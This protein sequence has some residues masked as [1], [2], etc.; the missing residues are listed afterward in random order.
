MGG[1]W[2][3]DRRRRRVAMALGAAAA[4]IFGPGLWHLAAMSAMQWRLDRQLAALTT[5]Q[6]QLAQEQQRLTSDPTYVE[7]LIRSTFKWA[8]KGE[9]VIPLDASSP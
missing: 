8:R 6:Q 1:A 9:V 3:Q 5:Q 4:A 2:W 7:G